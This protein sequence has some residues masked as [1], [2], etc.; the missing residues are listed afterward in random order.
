MKSQRSRPFKKFGVAS[1]FLSK[2]AGLAGGVPWN[3]DQTFSFCLLNWIRVPP[4]HSSVPII[5]T[6]PT[7]QSLNF[8]F[9][10]QFIEKAQWPIGY[11]V[12]L[13]I[14]RSSVRIRPWPLRWVLGQGSLLPLSQGEASTLASISY[15][16]VLVKY[17][18][19]KKKVQDPEMI[20]RSVTSTTQSGSAMNRS[21]SLRTCFHLLWF[22]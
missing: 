8:D 7:H 13:R 2:F 11:G 9:W 20:T 17:I 22:V 3:F 14:K 1:Q 16:A 12:G 15:L 19:A 18:L 6:F 10:V 21:R 4:Q 5:L